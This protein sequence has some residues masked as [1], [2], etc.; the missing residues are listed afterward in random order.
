LHLENINF[1]FFK[2]IDVFLKKSWICKP[3]RT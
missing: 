1:Y 3:H 2:K